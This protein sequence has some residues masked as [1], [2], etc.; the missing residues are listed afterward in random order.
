MST[1]TKL[2]KSDNVSRASG[3]GM[4]KHKAKRQAKR[5]NAYLAYKM[6]GT[7]EKN[8]KRKLQTRV[9]HHPNDLVAKQALSLLK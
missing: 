9:K 4:N 6:N 5:R 2:S 3:H 1:Q 7:R 8:K